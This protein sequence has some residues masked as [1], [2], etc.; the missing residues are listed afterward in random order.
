VPS[1]SLP[2][3]LLARTQGSVADPPESPAIKAA[4]LE[5][6]SVPTSQLTSGLAVV[7][8]HPAPSPV[9]PAPAETPAS[10]ETPVS[11]E[12]PSSAEISQILAPPT[13]YVRVAEKVPKLSVKPSRQ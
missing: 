12:T 5:N 1:Q 8:L 2:V 13:Q 9:L 6:L 10:A 11:T 7:S 3:N 4:P